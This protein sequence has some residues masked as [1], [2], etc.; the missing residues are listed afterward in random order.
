MPKGLDVSNGRQSPR[1][2][3]RGKQ[4][5]ET[6]SDRPLSTRPLEGP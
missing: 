4:A 3:D 2:T 1:L 6:I 5:A